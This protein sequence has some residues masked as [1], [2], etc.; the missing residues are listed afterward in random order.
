M[1]FKNPQT[2]IRSSSRG[3]ITPVEGKSNFLPAEIEI[4]NETRSLHR[5][6]SLVRVSVFDI[7]ANRG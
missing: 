7:K 1:G 3:F 2:R 6:P 5:I 4:D